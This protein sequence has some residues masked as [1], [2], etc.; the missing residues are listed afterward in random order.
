MEMYNDNILVR[1][2]PSD[3]MTTSG[4]IVPDSFME[5]SNKAV[6][7]SV[8]HGTEKH[9]KTLNEGDTIFHVKGAGTE[10]IIN[11]EKL[12]YMKSWDVLA[13]IPQNN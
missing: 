3:E 7:V 13:Y 9:P 1:P 6:L 10:L 5:R 12:Y 4:I 11:G 2:C 8:G